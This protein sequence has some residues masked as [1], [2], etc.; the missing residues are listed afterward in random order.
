MR[1]KE[2]KQSLVVAG[3]GMVGQRLLRAVVDQ[4]LTRKVD[5]AVFGE[6]LV[7]ATGSRPFVPPLPG[8]ELKG[9]FIYRTIA[10]V[11]Q[12]DPS[13]LFVKERC[14]IRPARADEKI[15]SGDLVRSLDV[16]VVR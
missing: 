11:E 1:T 10:D 13:P 6:E 3:H 4:G 7:L 12:P 8:R 2:P 5:V 14:Q 15:E 16:E 9:C